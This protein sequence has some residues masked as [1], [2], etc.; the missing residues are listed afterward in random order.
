M[1]NNINKITIFEFLSLLNSLDIKVWIENDQLRYRAPKGAMS[2][3][4]KHELIER[5][6]EILSCL[7]DARTENKLAFEPIL[8]IDRDGDLHLSFSQQRLWF[9]HQLD[10]Q[11]PAYNGN[12]QLR[13]TGAL[14][15]AVLEQSF[16]EIIRRHEALRTI[17]PTVDGLAVQ[18]IIPTLSISVPV[19]DIAGLEADEIQQIVTKEIHQ[20]FDLSV[21][22]LLRVILLRQEAE[23]H[24]LVLTMHHIITDAWSMEVFFKEL[25]FIYDAFI[26]KQP[27]PLPELAIQ[28]ADFATWQRQCFTQEVQQKQLE[29]WKQQLADAPPLLK[30]PTDYPRPAVQTFSGSTSRFQLEKDLTSQLVTLSQ[31]SG[32]T[33]F[34][35]LLAAYTVLL[36]RYSSQDDIC[37]GSPFANR[38]RQE[39]ESLIGFFANTLVLRTNL[40][41]NPSFHELIGRIREITM[42]AY[43][44]QD[45]PFEMLVEALQPQRDLS[46]TPLFQVTFIL[47]DTSTSPVE[48]SG[49]TVTSLPIE[50]TTTKFDLTL[51]IE[52][53]AAG[54]VSVWEYNTDLFDASTIERMAGHFQTLLAGIVTNP[55]EKI[56]QLPLLTKVEQHQLLVEWN[57]TQIDYPLD[58]CIHQLFEQQ[59]HLNPNAVAV[60]FENQQ[61]TYQ[62]LNCRANQL[63]HYL[64]SLGVKADVL[65]GICAERSLEMIVGLLGILKAGGAYV[66]LDPDYP[67]DRLSFMLE[68]AQVPVLLTQQQLLEKLPG[69][70]G[71]VIC[72]D[73]DW[74][75]ISVSSQNNPA[76]TVQ[77]TN[78]AYVI[79]TSGS[80][81]KPKGAMNTHLG[82][83]NR[84][85]WMQQAYQL[86]TVDCILQKTPFSFDVSVWEFFWP[87]ITGTRLVLAK[88]GGHK[89]SAYL[90]NLIQEQQVTT[91]HFVPSMLRAFVE[92]ESV[93][94][95][96]SLKRVICSGEALPKE[97]QESFFARLKCE[98]HN[99]YGPT[100]AAIDVTYW[101]CFPDSNLRTVPIGRPIPNT[102][103]YILDSH[104]QPVPVGVPGELHIGGVG[105]ALGYLNRSDLTNEKF[106]PNPFSDRLHSRL[107]KT[108]DLARYLSDGNIEYLGRIDHQ[109]KLRGFRIEL[110]EI[111]STLTQHQAV[112]ETIVI[113][114]EDDPGNKRLVAYIVPDQKYAFPILQLLR[115]QNK[116]L[117]DEG[118]LYKLPNGMMIAHLNKNETEFV[119]KEL[120]EEQT[121]LKHGITINEGD[122]IFDVGANIGLFTLFVGQICKD[123]SIYAFEPIPPVFEL[124]RRNAE[125]YSLNV[126]LF[127]LGLS[128]ET[129]SDTFTYYPQISV[130]SGRF[131]DAEQERE[132]VKSFLLKQQNIVENETEISS[133]AIDELL[134]ERLQSQQFT[135][136]LKTISDVMREHGVEKVDLLKIDVEKSEQ[137]VLSGIQQED[138][139]KIKQIVVEVHNING[140]LEE[141]TALLKKH[142][143]DLIIEQDALLEE[144]VLYNIYARR[145]SINQYLLEEPDRELVSDRVKPT[146]I[147]VSLLLSEVR[148]FLQKKLPEYMIP[149]AFVLLESLPLTP[150][151]KVDRKALPIPDS[152]NT[153]PEK[154]IA[155]RTPIEELL[156][157]IWAQVLKVEQAGINDNFFELGGHSLLGT[158]VVSRIRSIFQVELPLRELFANTTLVQLAQV[159]EQ[160]QQQDLDVSASPI[161][162]RA[163]NADLPLSFA[164]QRLW[165]LDQL[166]PNSALYNIPI[167]VRL[168]GN[169]QVTALEQSLQEIITRHEALRTNFIIVDGQPTQVIREQRTEDREQKLFSIVDLTHLSATQQE[170]TAQQLVQQQAIQTFDLASDALIRATLL[171]LNETEHILLVCMHHVVSDGWSMGVFVQELAALYNAYSLNQVSPL[172]PLPIQYADFAI[173]QRNWLQ[174]DVLQSQLSYWEQQLKDAPA[175]LALPTDRPRPAVQT[176]VGAHHEFALSQELSQKLVKLSQE[177]GCTMFMTLL[178]AF[179]TLIYRYTGQSDIL[180]GTPIANRD[181]SEIEGLIGFFVNTL[182]MRSNLAGNPSF[183]E[184]LDRVREM[185]MRAYTHQHLPFE[186]LVEALQPERD[187]GHTPLFQVIFMLQNATRQELEL[188]GLTVSSLPVESKTAKVDLGLSME[189]TTQGLVGVWEYNTDL[190]DASTIERMTGHFVTLLEGIVANPQQQISQ[191]PLLTQIEQQQLLVEWNNT[192]AD[193][194]Q[195]KCIHQLFEEQVQRTPDAVAVVF[196]N[197]QL[198][199][200]QLNYRANGLAHYLRSLGVKPDVLVGICVERS[201][202]M[203]VGLLGILKAGGAYL[204]LDP[205]YPTERLRFMLE[206]AQ[207]SVL[208]TQQRLIDRL[209]EN[210]ANLHFGLPRLRSAQ[211]AQCKVCLDEVWEQIA[212]NNQDN[213]TSGV[214][215]FNLANLIYTSGSTGKP[216]GVMVEHKGLCNLA[217]AM[218][219]TFGVNSDSRVLQFASFSFDASIAEILKALGSGATLY[220]ATKDSLLPGKP[221]IEQ[222]RKHSITHITLPPSALAVMPL[223][224]LPA[225]QTIIVG[226]EACSAEL[227]KQWSAGRNLFN[228]YGPTEASVCATIAKCT[229]ADEKVTI[230]KAIANT[231]IYILDEYLQPVPVGVPGELHIGGVGL[232]RGYLNR[233]EL[234]QEKFINNPFYN[235]K[236]SFGEASYKIQNSKLYKTG[237]LV[238]YLPDGNIEYLGR[239]DHQVKI[240]GFRI[241]LGEIEAA[242]SQHDRVQI[243]CVVARVENSGEKGLVA[244]VGTQKDATLTT[245]ELRQF[246]AD[247]LPGYMLPSAFV[248]LESLP[249]TP[250]GKVDRRALPNPDLHQKIS[251]YVMPNT[252]IENIIAGIWQQALAIEKVGIYNNFFELGGHSLLLVRINQQ[253]Q[254]KI[255]MQL[256]IVDMFSYPTIHSFSQYLITKINQEETTKQNQNRTQAY[257]ELKS[258]KN[259][260]LQSRQQYRSQRKR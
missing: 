171:V 127:N 243:C 41:G 60:V 30:L 1:S 92:E 46:H 80:T 10:K 114:R 99:L 180:V 24:L 233:P 230:G 4:I 161:L 217:Q 158:Q 91:L 43:T 200:Q 159:I 31:K 89:D 93:K 165:F 54:L 2:P 166:K 101:Q 96:S 65:V 85:L 53:T 220:L 144:T 47:Q 78:L 160:L 227:I 90:V 195:D 256:S 172:A 223:E 212:Q 15:V 32:V 69:H 209:P 66:P 57:D 155:P 139:Q 5:K 12:V 206:D 52:N 125:N 183:S 169:L 37:I 134:A 106:I 87:L 28:Y 170:I 193:Y 108:G 260:R 19:L 100:E 34:M 39:L 18:K 113:D 115:F 82:I 135:C 83:C 215:A 201:L 210:Q 226:G 198:T 257:S 119:Y 138:W 111:E 58:K 191:L 163:K 142:G 95:C 208:L 173:W 203:V 84:L 259:Q 88:P 251:D 130:I 241:E 221:L 205:E 35:T 107:Y 228:A 45:L 176:F 164:Q 86:T 236:Y 186:M 120:W 112:G 51:L 23:S 177:Q 175:L 202:E 187:L 162:A 61:L 6:K 192:Q 194:P 14:N 76:I 248:I 26:K 141:I 149:S 224:E 8:P 133:Q 105:L 237:D 110:G 199:Y 148:Q 132:V 225:L 74:Q 235:S 214:R 216:K 168:D 36:H 124:L 103:I 245:S 126:K 38:D 157:Q 189:N 118:S 140:R 72:L 182:V 207:V 11:N 244:Y 50:T 129:K 98:L 9:I 70:Q 152:Y 55:E 109:V 254:E 20:P 146:W 13:I 240:R 67:Q 116:N 196:E 7:Q 253:L 188:A 184:L 94:N 63:A 252:E 117:F 42:E 213:P 137:D 242:L 150:N 246:L 71:Q 48:L 64:K 68:D 25:G 167:A 190:F 97:L 33:L 16:N 147:D 81:G 21:A 22:P 247:K 249:L 211:V 234:T 197:Q 218:I 229:D 185:A 79:Y 179:D 143:Y 178:A 59:V 131:A 102:Q 239:I 222:L 232:A 219:Q 56:L 75:S 27:N 77:G 73:T 153:N 17:F 123:V 40:A 122:C 174:G 121:Y 44:H 258:L 156:A 204:P 104:L 255:G 49:L 145:P 238:R 181:R 62:Q 136:Q 3:A 231:Q 29:Y 154:Y 250:N 151:G 128:S